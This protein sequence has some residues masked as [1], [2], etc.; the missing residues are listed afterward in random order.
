MSSVIKDM[1][2]DALNPLRPYKLFTSQHQTHS[3]KQIRFISG[4]QIRFI[5]GEKIRFISRFISGEQIRFKSSMHI[6]ALNQL[7]PYFARIITL[8]EEIK[9]SFQIP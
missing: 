9:N 3:P 1:H 8:G 4:E 2:I 6:D 5:S 7:I